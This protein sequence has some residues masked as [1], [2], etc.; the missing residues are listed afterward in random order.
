MMWPPKWD[1][2][3]LL[4]DMAMAQARFRVERRDEPREA[5]IK[6]ID[7]YREEFRTLFAT[8]GVAEP[9]RITAAQLADIFR[10][11]LGAALRYLPGPPI[12][13]DDLKIMAETSLSPRRI[14]ADEEA[15]RRILQIIVQTVDVRRFPWIAEDRKPTC[16][17]QSAA[18]LASATL[19]AAQRVATIRRNAVKQ[20]QEEAVRAALGSIG[21][22][23]VK[24]R[25]IPNLS[26][27]PEPGEFCGESLV[28]SRKADVVVRLFDG[29]LMPIE[30]KVSNSATN[31]VKRLNNDAMQ[32]AARWYRELGEN[33]VIPTAIMSGVYKLLNLK[34]A[35]AAG[36]YLF[37]A[38]RL[39]EILPFIEA[40]RPNTA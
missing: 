33:Q 36:L 32:K 8:Y 13:G 4:T 28:G 22:K 29:R 11:K 34:Q 10:N 39:D 38:H 30:C 27:A 40:T 9:H 31:S 14:A 15:A 3:T 26:T 20:A 24:R 12:S 18:I 21:L 35:Q 19:I 37:W 23:E 6:V 1:D 2:Q 16:D 17:E 5:W 7:E 25:K